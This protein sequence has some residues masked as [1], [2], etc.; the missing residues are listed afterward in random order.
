MHFFYITFS[1]FHIQKSFLH[2]FLRIW[3]KRFIEIALVFFSPSAMLLSLYKPIRIME[4]IWFGERVFK[5]AIKWYKFSLPSIEANFKV[6]KFVFGK[7]DNC[8]GLQPINRVAY[9]L[10]L[11]LNTHAIKWCMWWK[12]G[13][14]CLENNVKWHLAHLDEPNVY[15]CSFEQNIWHLTS[16]MR[17]CHRRCRLVFFSLSLLKCRFWC[18]SHFPIRL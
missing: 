2:T 10:L 5:C 14:K 18:R 7:I 3:Y 1:I 15:E 17:Y 6:H 12:M 11:L 8:W 4:P 9:W 16:K 13:E